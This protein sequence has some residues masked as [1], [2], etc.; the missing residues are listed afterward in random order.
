MA[1]QFEFLDAANA[2][3]RYFITITVSRGIDAP[4]APLNQPFT[5]KHTPA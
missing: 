4:E 3:S 1:L 2:R 5:P